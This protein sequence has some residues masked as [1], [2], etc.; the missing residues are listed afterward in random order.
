LLQESAGG[1]DLTA[2]L[3]CRVDCH[4]LQL[5]DDI[6]VAEVACLHMSLLLFVI[7]SLMCTT[8]E[9]SELDVVIET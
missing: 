3:G 7:S 2:V 4:N 6:L 1:N 8:T 9:A 5:A